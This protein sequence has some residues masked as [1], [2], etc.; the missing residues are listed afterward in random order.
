MRPLRILRSVFL[1]PGVEVWPSG[2]EVRSLT[3]PDSVNVQRMYARRK[4]G[5]IQI[6]SATA[7]NFV[8]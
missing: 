3:L 4:L 1:S 8:E 5:N 6:D 7:L 2:L